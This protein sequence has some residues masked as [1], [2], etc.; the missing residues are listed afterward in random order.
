MEPQLDIDDIQGHVFPGFGT[1][2]S[3]VIALRMGNPEGGRVALAS[4]LRDVTTMADSLGN[5]ESRREFM[6]R[7]TPIPTQP[8]PSLAISVAATAVRAWGFDTRGFDTSF[9]AGMRVD[10][11]ALGDCIGSNSI[12]EDWTF[13]VEDNDR[14]DVL[15]VAG[16]STRTQLEQ[17]VQD[18]FTKLLPAFTP[19]ITEYGHRRAGDEEFFGFNDGVSQPAMRGITPAG[20]HLSRRVIAEDDP[21]SSIYSKPGQLLIWPGSFLFGY[22]GQTSSLTQAGATVP[23]PVPWMRN[24]SYLV[25]RRLLQD[26]IAFRNAVSGMEQHLS[27]EGEQVPDGWV[28]AHLVGR[29]PDGTPLTASPEAADPEISENAYRINNFRFFASLSPTPLADSGE[30]AQTLPAV[31]ADP[32][33]HA[34]P[35][36]SHIRKVNPRDGTSEI[37]QEHHPRKLML[38]RGIAF[39]PEVDD[40]PDADRGLLFL[41][42]Q[43]SIVEQFKF[44]QVNWA[45]ATQRPTGDGRDPI[46]GQDGTNHTERRVQIFGPSGRQLRCPFNGRWVIATGGE[47]FLTPSISGLRYLLEVQNGMPT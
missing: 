28:A 31:P 8:A 44:V 34:C 9:H 40:A 19:V 16:H 33:G 15:I 26:V 27:Q 14:V 21:R 1:S 22:P 20:E 2:H 5:K 42:Y 32:M 13:N 24:G 43:T 10:A 47:Y 3:V 6:L 4:L 29:W 23:P 18:W 12:P 30:P 36:A 11:A 46:I 35:R 37:G 17:T 7:G 25:F 41:S 38:R 39:G 45:N